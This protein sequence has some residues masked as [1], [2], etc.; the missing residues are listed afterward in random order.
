VGKKTWMTLMS[1]FI[2][3]AIVGVLG[4]TSSATAKEGNKLVYELKASNARLNRKVLGPVTSELNG[5]PAEPVHS[6][7][8][9][10]DGSI[11]L[12]KAKAQ[13]EIDPVNNTGEIKVEWTDRHGKWTFEQTAFLPLP[14]HPLGLRLGSVAAGP[15]FEPEDPVTVNVYLHGD[16]TAGGPVLPT[17]FN[18]LATWGPAK[19][20]LNGEPFDNPYDGP[21]PLWVAHTMTTSGVRN[22][23]GTVTVNGGE[24]YNP[25]LQGAVGDI[26]YNDMEF[27]LVFHDAPGPEMTANFPPPLAFFY[28][29]TFEDVELEIKHIE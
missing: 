14:P 3:L 2:I 21:V 28:H 22:D 10:G 13:Y 8:W 29:L 27:H 11:E 23:D 12:E 17:V 18:M 24:I 25:M 1:I 20:T 26:D 16:T 9:D 4:A 6:F 15:I 19:I 5:V 7:V